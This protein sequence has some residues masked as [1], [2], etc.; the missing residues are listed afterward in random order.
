[1]WEIFHLLNLFDSLN[2]QVIPKPG[3]Y[4]SALELILGFVTKHVR[5]NPKVAKKEIK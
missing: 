2:W 4:W 3:P 1:M 5:Q